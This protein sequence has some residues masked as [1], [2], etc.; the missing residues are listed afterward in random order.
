MCGG[1]EHKIR[2]VMRTAEMRTAS[3]LEGEAARTVWT[4]VRWMKEIPHHLCLDS[5]DKEG[6]VG[7]DTVHP[8]LCKQTAQPNLSPNRVLR[9]PVPVHVFRAEGS[10]G[11]G[12]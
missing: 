4:R 11:Q 3:L 10:R 5:W 7:F 12:I 2:S 6:G 8:V 1:G 9:R